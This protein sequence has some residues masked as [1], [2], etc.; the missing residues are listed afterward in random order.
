[1][2]YYLPTIGTNDK[3]YTWYDHNNRSCKLCLLV[4]LMS[5]RTEVPFIA[6]FGE[7]L[8]LNSLEFSFKYSFKFPRA[9]YSNI[10]ET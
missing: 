2:S 1:M 10:R 8:S 3:S 6:T 7:M 4:L 9:Q 5:S